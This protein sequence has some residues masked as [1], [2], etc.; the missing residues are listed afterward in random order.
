MTVEVQEREYFRQSF[1][2][3]YENDNEKITT[4]IL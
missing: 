2:P 4:Q 3:G 1:E